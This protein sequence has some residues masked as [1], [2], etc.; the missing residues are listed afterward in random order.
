MVDGIVDEPDGIVVPFGLEVHCAAYANLAARSI[1][2]LDDF[3]LVLHGFIN[4]NRQDI[5]FLVAI[6]NRQTVVL[7][8]V[9]SEV[10]WVWILLAKVDPSV[11]FVRFHLGILDVQKRLITAASDAGQED[12]HRLHGGV[13]A[14]G[15]AVPCLSLHPKSLGDAAQSAGGV[16]TCEG[17]A[18]SPVKVEL[19]LI[20]IG[21]ALAIL[22]KRV[23]FEVL[24][25]V[26][27]EE[28][29]GPPTCGEPLLT[30]LRKKS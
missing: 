20:K 14:V 11:T 25:L 9:N 5:D 3:C 12:R 2:N 27:E 6:G 22:Q 19:N 17:A 7:I 29:E 8:A 15:I 24:P 18:I 16:A 26:D 21:V 1:R 13:D 28:V 23:T 30:M 4:I 10:C